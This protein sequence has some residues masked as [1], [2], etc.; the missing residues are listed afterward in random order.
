MSATA[1]VARIDEA[2]PVWVMGDE[3]RFLGGIEDSDL[4]VVEVRIPP[5]SGTPPHRHRSLEIFRVTEGEITFGLFGDGPPRLVVGG[6]GTVVTLP[7]NLGHNYENRSSR[8]AAMTAV[9][10][11][12]MRDFFREVGTATPPPPGPPAA[13][14]IEK[15]MAACRRHGIEVLSPG[16]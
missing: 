6:P 16:R 10:E 8:P 13:A 14:V 15:I 9:V 2:V 7:S 5:G 11:G 1:T 3:L 12:Q 4:H